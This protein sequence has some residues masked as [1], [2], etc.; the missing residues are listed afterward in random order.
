MVRA[1]APSGDPSGTVRRRPLRGVWITV[2]T[3]TRGVGRDGPWDTEAVEC[4]RAAREPHTELQG[5][6]PS[7]RATCGQHTTRNGDMWV[8]VGRGPRPVALLQSGNTRVTV[9]N[10]QKGRGAYD[11]SLFGLGGLPGPLLHMLPSGLATA[12]RCELDEHTEGSFRR[13]AVVKCVFVAL[14]HQNHAAVP[15]W[16]APMPGLDGHHT[17]MS[18]PSEH[19]CP[20]W[21]D[22]IAAFKRP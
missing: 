5:D 17:Y 4:L 14:L 9:A 11:D 3:R 13:E 12:L 21:D 22:L 15:C 10:F 8:G 18:A 2:P 16:D 6:T 1:N 7:S 19:P 20:G